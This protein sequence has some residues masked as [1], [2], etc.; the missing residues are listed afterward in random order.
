MSKEAKYVCFGQ[1][2]EDDPDCDNCDDRILCRDSKHKGEDSGKVICDSCEW[3][4][5]KGKKLK[6]KHFSEKDRLKLVGMESFDCPEYQLDH[7][8]AAD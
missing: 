7:R 5:Q 8:L 2:V 6:C 1:F 3:Y 4:V